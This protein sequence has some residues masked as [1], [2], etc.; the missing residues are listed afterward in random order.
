[1]KLLYLLLIFTIVAFGGCQVGPD[2]SPPE[3]KMPDVWQ[4]E[5]TKGLDSGQADLQTWWLNLNDPVL[6]DLIEKAGAENLSLKIAAARIYEARAV[7][8]IASGQWYPDVNAAGLYNRSRPS[9]SFVPAGVTPDQ[10]NFHSTGFD[11]SWEIDVF[12]R[13]SRSVESA[14]AGL[15]ASIEDYRDVLVT[16]YADIALNYVQVRTL[17]ARLYYAEENVAAQKKTMQLTKDRLE[18]GIAPELDVYQAELNLASTESLI[19]TLQIFLM[20]SIN[21]LSVLLGERPGTLRERL[22]EHATVPKPPENLAVDLPAELLRQ[23]PDIR[24]SERDLAA[25]TARIGIATADLYPRFSLSGTFAVEGSQMRDLGN[26]NNRAWSFGPSFRWN[27]FDGDRIRNSIKVEDARTKQALNRYELTVLQALEEVEN[28]MVGYAQ[29]QVRYAALER[30][31]QA[32]QRSVV[33]VIEGLYIPG[34]TDFQNVLDMQRSLF[35]QQDQLAESEGLVI[36]EL[37]RLYK[38]LG[39]GWAT[40]T[41]EQ[42]TYDK[43]AYERLVD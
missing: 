38:A 16:L 19:P 2:Y 36:Q 31:A 5:L 11:S 17:Q 32:A 6:N 41:E 1:M 23:R 21:R 20:Q 43:E 10:S 14:D 40:T 9:E 3:I 7:R 33:V 42:F 18:A 22:A 30:S 27:L 29:Q 13:I 34:L 8:G 28:S 37:I 24:R 35:V 25:Q 26:I 15:E 4:Q 12:G 39:G